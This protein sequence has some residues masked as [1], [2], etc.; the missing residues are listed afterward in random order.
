MLFWWEWELLSFFSISSFSFKKGE[1]E[2]RTRT[3]MGNNGFGITIVSV[4]GRIPACFQNAL[5]SLLIR[6]DNSLARGFSLC[7]IEPI[8]SAGGG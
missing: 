1:K 6:Q 2:R 3:G 8:K 5:S 7:Y 4:A